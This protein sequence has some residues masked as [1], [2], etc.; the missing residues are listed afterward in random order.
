MPG[1]KAKKVMSPEEKEAYYKKQK[2]KERAKRR[3]ESSATPVAGDKDR[4]KDE[5]EKKMNARMSKAGRTIYEV[6]SDGNC[7]FYAISH[8]LECTDRKEVSAG[9]L[10]KMCANYLRSNPDFFVPFLEESIDFSD[11]CNKIADTLQ[12][13]GPHEIRSLS[14]VLQVP[15]TVIQ[16][17]GNNQHF[18]ESFPD[19]PLVLSYHRHQHVLSEHYNSAP[20]RPAAK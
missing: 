5:E 18:G 10:R 6:P 9:A 8:Q 13:G 11:Y 16:A 19:P 17:E 4:L 3:K 2:E 12:W 1:K 20:L 15:I 7:L 14:Q